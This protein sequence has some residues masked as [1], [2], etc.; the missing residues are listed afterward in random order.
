MV[1]LTE[2]GWG[3][4]H[5]AIASSSPTSHPRGTAKQVHWFNEVQKMTASPPVAVRLSAPFRRWTSA[6]CSKGGR[7][8]LSYT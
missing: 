6:T 2:V 1:T 7:A 5:P 4:D 8:D 3:A